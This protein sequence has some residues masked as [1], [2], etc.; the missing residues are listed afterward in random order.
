[1]QIDSQAQLTRFIRKRHNYV[2][3][4]TNCKMRLLDDKL[5]YNT[6][7]NRLTHRRKLLLGPWAGAPHFWGPMGSP[8]VKPTHF[9][10][11]V[12]ALFITTP[13]KR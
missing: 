12:F 10:T 8:I 11:G 4:P 13:A 2:A 1:L 6:I 7:I 3:L 9:S 5:S